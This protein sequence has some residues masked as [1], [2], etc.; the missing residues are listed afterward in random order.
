MTKKRKNLVIDYTARDFNSIRTRLI[1]HARK[2]YPETYQDF[3]DLSFGSLLIDM[4][5][6]VG[7]QMSLYLD[8]SVNELFLPTATQYSNVVKLGQ[9]AGYKHDPVPA[10]SLIHI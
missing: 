6:Y 10:L 5:S 4:I 7:D 3:S 1:E 2:Y 9:Q 8:H